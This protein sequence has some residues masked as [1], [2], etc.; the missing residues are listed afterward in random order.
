M[1]ATQPDLPAKARD[2]FVLGITHIETPIITHYS[3][4]STCIASTIK[5]LAR[6]L[7]EPQA[8]KFGK[9]AVPTLRPLEE[10]HASRRLQDSFTSTLPSAP[11][12]GRMDFAFAF[13]PM[14]APD[15][16]PVQLAS[17]L[18]P[19]VFDRTLKLITLD[20]A[21]YVRSIVA[22]E[23]QLQKQ[24]IKMSSL[25][26][27][28][29]KGGQGSKRMRTTR[30]ALSA[31]EGGSRSS[32]RGERWFSADINPYLVAKTAGAG[33]NGF[34]DGDLE[35]PEEP[36][37]SVGSPMSSPDTIPAK[38]PK[39]AVLKS[40]KRKKVLQDEDDVDELSLGC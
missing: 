31:L 8:E 27:E 2:D 32:T 26:S 18:E 6:S 37:G 12:I 3:S 4:L 13:D 1:D 16:S 24:R 19:S 35:P 21:P 34:E 39:R 40:R 7:L 33:W 10:A 17:Y 38:G 22:Y 20:V 5:S 28:G 29:G 14:A 9:Q 11:A 15:T 36:Q 30:A 23:S 25:V